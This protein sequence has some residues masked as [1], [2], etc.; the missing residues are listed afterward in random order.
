[1]KFYTKQERPAELDL[2]PWEDAA[3]LNGVFGENGAYQVVNNA[4]DAGLSLRRDKAKM[5]PAGPM[6]APTGLDS[7]A[8]ELKL[9][10]AHADLTDLEQAV[11]Q[12]MRF[13]GGKTQS[14]IAETLGIS[15]SYYSKM[16]AEDGPIIQKLQRARKTIYQIE[17]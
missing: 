8:E 6:A 2:A 11:F 3:Y 7:V 5:V 9:F 15:Q 16:A 14:E 17:D 10:A 13:P 4:A 12:F 1:V